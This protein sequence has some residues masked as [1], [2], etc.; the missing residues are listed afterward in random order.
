MNPE[1]LHELTTQL[2]QSQNLCKWLEL[3]SYLTWH[4]IGFIRKNQFLKITETSVTQD[5]VFQLYLLSL[6]KALPIKLYESKL[7]NTNGNDLEILLETP[8]G[9][10]MFPAQAKIIY[11]NHKYHSITHQVKGR[12]QIDLLMNY[13]KKIKGI[14]LY[15]LYNTCLDNKIYTQVSNVSVYDIESFGCS[16]TSAQVIKQNFYRKSYSGNWKIPGFADLHCSVAYPLS[17]LVCSFS[18]LL[19]EAFI[20][21]SFLY[22][23]HREQIQF[24]STEQIN[25]DPRWKNILPAPEMGRLSP[26]ELS[27]KQKNYNYIYRFNPKFRLVFSQTMQTQNSGLWELN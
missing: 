27:I 25:K 23:D 22:F 18:N 7:E 19:K 20:N 12:Y 10:V 5:L 17:T 4:K 8:Q 3:Y 9:Y 1:K 13:A 21:S 26:N 14:P 15:L 24:Y 2:E 16:I 11:A 6:T